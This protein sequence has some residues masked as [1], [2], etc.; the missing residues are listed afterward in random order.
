VQSISDPLNLLHEDG[1]WFARAHELRLW[2]IG[3]DATL[4]NP[5][6][7]LVPKLEF[8]ADNKSA[9][10]VLLDAHTKA[11]DG[12]QL[13]A[14][15]LAADWA[16]RVEAFAEAGVAQGAVKAAQGPNAFRTT[17]AAIGQ[18][19]VAPL[20]GL[21]IV[22]APTI[23]QQPERLESDLTALMGDPALQHCRWVLVLDL[24]APLPQVLLDALGPQRALVT[25]CDIDPDQ[26]RRDFSAMLGG[27]PARFG[28]AFPVGVT[29]PRR[30]DEPPLPKEQRDAALRAEGIDPA[31]IDKGPEIR[32]KA[33]GASIAMKD[34]R[35]AEA[36]EQQRQ[37]RDLFASVGQHELQ[38]IAQI[39]LA[40]YL[41]GL[42]Q[43]PAAKREL[44]AAIEVSRTHGLLRPESQAHLA[45]G[46]LHALDEEH[47][48]AVRAYAD[49]GRT[50]EAAGE[51]MLAIESWRMAGQL[52]GKLRQD[53]AAV[54][55]FGEALRIAE[56][57]PPAQLERSSAPEAA[58]QLAALY[59]RRGMQ[60]QAASLHVHA[61]AM[62][63]GE[64]TPV[65][66]GQ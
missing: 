47:P 9:W 60:A 57:T 53:D 33:L 34:G 64:E 22:L 17:A 46:L 10:P 40:S 14:N 4:R 50:A 26:Q 29:P 65:D 55:A 21:V 18:A 1:S 15:V 30:V 31:L 58:R 7:A 37:V 36:I 63:R 49:A 13:R 27:N 25:R 62:E 16:R 41:S 24:E 48:A 12:W 35:G 61:D 39:T 32:A 5:V 6:L 11:D 38:V 52:T 59:E 51:P 23:V 44:Q 66:A 2:V 43:R 19:M 45:L 56:G 3:C 42:E 28:M 20:A 8:H 54:R